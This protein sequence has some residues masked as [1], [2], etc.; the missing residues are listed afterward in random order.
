MCSGYTVEDIVRVNYWAL[1]MV[2]HQMQE[3]RW[4]RESARS[5]TEHKRGAGHWGMERLLAQCPAEM[6]R[7]FVNVRM[8][9]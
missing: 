9:A 8:G 1:K 7:R 4:R 6:A 2:V 5:K 3:T